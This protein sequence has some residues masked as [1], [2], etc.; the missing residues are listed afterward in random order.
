[1]ASMVIVLTPA[2]QEP[3][4]VKKAQISAL[5]INPLLAEQGVLEYKDPRTCDGVCSRC[6]NLLC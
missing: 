6:I 5:D 4:L 1:M 2:A 3:V